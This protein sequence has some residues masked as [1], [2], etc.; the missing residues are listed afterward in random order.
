[1]LAAAQGA[2][3]GRAETPHADDDTLVVRAQRSLLLAVA[4]AGRRLVAVGAHGNILLSDDNGTTWRISASGTSSL[5][6]AVAFESSD[7]GW[8]VGYDATILR[9]TDAGTTWSVQQQDKS[10]DTVLYSVTPASQAT[11]GAKPDPAVAI[12][13]YGLALALGTAGWAPFRVE[14]EGDDYHLNSISR[15]A[16]GGLGITAEGGQAY[17]RLPNEEEWT[18]FPL[19]YEGSQFGSLPTADGGMLSFGLRG[20]LFRLGAGEKPAW[21]RIATNL[22]SGF[23]GGASIT[24][25][26]IAL[27]GTDGTVLTGIPDGSPL[28]LVPFENRQTLGGVAE[29]EDGRLVVVGERGVSVVTLG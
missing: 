24:G 26:R 9:T 21:E 20:S 16:G 28:K 2:A 7:A 8:V 29:A 25:G 17:R 5:L 4:R 6:T 10:K 14:A 12:G 15:L 1:M 23:M 13:E 18:P 22:E 11:G 27:V 19:P 3:A